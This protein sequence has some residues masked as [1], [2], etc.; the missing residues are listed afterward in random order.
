MI[1]LVWV[2][3]AVLLGCLLTVRWTDWRVLEPAW[4]RWLLIFGAGAAGGIALTA[5]LFA[6]VGV[7]AGSPR[8]ALALEIAGLAAAAWF[9]F[10]RLPAAAESTPAKPF[11]LRR[12]LWAA[13]AAAGALATAGM[14]AA[15][16][17]NPQGNWDAWAIWNLRA[18][19]LAAGAGLAQRA[20][21]PALGAV[22]HTEYPLLL[23]SFVARAWSYGHTMSAAVPAATSYV[24]F[25]ALVALAVGGIAVLRGRA[26]GLAAGL[27]LLASPALLR[28]VPAQYADVPLACYFTAAVIF[29]LLERPVPAGIFAGAAACTKDEGMLFLAVFLAATLALR[30]R[31]LWGTV[32]GALPGALLELAFKVSL[33]K[34]GTSLAA[35]TLPGMGHRALDPARY[36]MI[37]ASLAREFA[38]LG[39][40]WYHPLLPLIALAIALKFGREHGR[41]LAFS[42]ATAGA[43]LLGYCGVYAVTGYDLAWQLQ[44]SMGRLLVQVWPLA[45]LTAML[46]LRAP[47]TW[48]VVTPAAKPKARRKAR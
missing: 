4:A 28:E 30:R 29:A 12:T 35:V 2:I 9:A 19:F 34:S 40:G 23:S 10:R 41:D 38:G 22:T 37:A 43:L 33:P 31:A 16:Q 11:P 45:V 17:W 25:L 24:L 26:L 18:R 27:V 46:A 15:W 48:A 36:G 44:S 13:L 8:A 6:L 47:E 5:C 21:S 7:A 32:A 20:W 1:G 39:V 3:E 14:A 42:G